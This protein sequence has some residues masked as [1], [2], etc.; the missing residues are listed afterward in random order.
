MPDV[1]YMGLQDMSEPWAPKAIP[2]NSLTWQGGFI[3]QSPRCMNVQY[4]A[5]D[6][7]KYSGDCEAAQPA[8][9]FAVSN[10]STVNLCPKDWVVRLPNGE[11]H[12]L[13]RKDFHQRCRRDPVPA[14]P[15]ALGEYDP[16]PAAVPG[17]NTVESLASDGMPDFGSPDEG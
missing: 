2:A 17:P 9:P 10:P 6:F 4:K 11:I 8:R 13:A 3:T 7:E 12:G 5:S 14:L 1:M 15:P 16:A